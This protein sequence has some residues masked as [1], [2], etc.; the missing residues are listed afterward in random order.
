MPFTCKVGDT[1]RLSDR[2]GSH[3]YVIL[4]N[5]NSDGNVVVVNFT[6]ARYW[7]EWIV[8]FTRK[9][10]RKLFKKKTT[11][12]FADARIIS[13]SKLLAIA[14]LKSTVDYNYCAENI[15][16]EIII[17][18]FQSQFTPIEV[19]VELGIQYPDEYESYYKKGC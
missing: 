7:K 5:S 15:T 6:T 9:D 11:V 19:I 14:K 1:L 3:H 18:A 4:T 17:G 16:K 8:Q 2:G 12:N 13:A 10:N